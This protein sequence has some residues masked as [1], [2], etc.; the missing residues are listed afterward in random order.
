VDKAEI[1]KDQI[2]RE[3]ITF[4]IWLFKILPKARLWRILLFMSGCAAG[5]VHDTICEWVSERNPPR[6]IN[7]AG[8]LL[9]VSAKSSKNQ[10]R[11]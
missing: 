11:H 3:L 8:G 2:I 6:P 7:P 10:P 5:A 1:V 9:F 4:F